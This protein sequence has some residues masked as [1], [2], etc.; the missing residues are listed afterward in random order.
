MTEKLSNL[1][2]ITELES[3]RK[4][5]KIKKEETSSSIHAL[6]LPLPASVQAVADSAWDN[7]L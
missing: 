7:L 5:I 3:G 6:P 2:K 1:P 4:K